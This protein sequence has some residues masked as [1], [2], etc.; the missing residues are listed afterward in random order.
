MS[1]IECTHSRIEPFINQRHIETFYLFNF[2]S[3]LFRTW[4]LWAVDCVD[5]VC[6]S[7]SSLTSIK[8][9]ESCIERSKEWSEECLKRHPKNQNEL[10]ALFGGPADLREGYI[11]HTHTHTVH[12]SPAKD[13]RPE[14][15]ELLNQFSGENL[16]PENENETEPKP[17]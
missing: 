14:R 12:I 4:H 1:R 8:C 6:V 13:P 3:I 11:T 10:L 7:H 17:K 5:Y 16:S 9:E 15:H 2:N